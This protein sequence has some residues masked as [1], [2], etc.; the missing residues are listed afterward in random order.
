MPLLP[1]T[2]LARE[3]KARLPRLTLAIIGLSILLLVAL[4]WPLVAGFLWPAAGRA[5][6]LALQLTSTP[7]PFQPSGTPSSTATLTL[8]PDPGA[9]FEAGGGDA[10]SGTILLSLSEQGYAQLFWHRLAGEP[11]TRLT[12]GEW[13]D[14]HPAANPSNS[15]I[16]FASNRSGSWD[17]YLLDLQNGQ[18]QQ[19]SED[20]AYDGHPSWSADGTWLAYERNDSDNLEIYIRPADGSVEPVLISAHAALDYSPTWRPGRQELAFVSERS[21]LAQLW[22]VDLEAGGNRRFRQLAPSEAAQAAPAW[23]ADGDWL[24]WGQQ[25]GGVWAIYVQDLSDRTSEPRR[26]GR[27]N[28]PQWNLS[29]SALLAELQDATQTYLTAYAIRGGLALAP[30]VLPGRLEGAAWANYALGENLPPPLAAAARVTPVADWL[31]AANELASGH[32][33]SLDD[34]RA[35]YEELNQSALAAFDALREH[36]A[37]WLGWD[38]LSSLDNAY[39]PLGYL[40]PPDRQQDWLY[41]GRAFELHGALLEAGWMAAVREEFEGQ[42]YWRIYLKAA[43]QAGGP[44]RPLT[45]LPWDFSAHYLGGNDSA[46]AGGQQAALAPGGY[47]VDFTALAAEYGFERVPALNNWRSYYHGALFNQFVLRAGLS[48]QEAMLQLYSAEDLSGILTTSSP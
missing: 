37:Q 36:T 47:W 2:D 30:E 20:A 23:S 45:A 19:L 35:P 11:F 41:T 5:A 14:I 34:V 31:V 46:L 18:T 32:T 21:G 40:L 9:P 29:G 24:A 12:Q 27:G 13:D 42:S 28:N 43:E 6:S 7:S 10:L 17:L 22:L 48:W 44:G 4:S 1:P 3:A 25:E 33:G 15:L 26:L 16:A 39:L 8:T 38:A